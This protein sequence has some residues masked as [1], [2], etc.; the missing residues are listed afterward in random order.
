VT[1]TEELLVPMGDNESVRML[2]DEIRASCARVMDQARVLH[3][4]LMAR[5][6]LIQEAR[7][8]RAKWR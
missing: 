2:R 7:R 6:A 5:L 8:P 4:E 3:E 1:A